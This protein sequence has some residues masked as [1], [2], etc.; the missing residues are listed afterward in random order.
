METYKVE[1]RSPLHNELINPTLK[2]KI[3]HKEITIR[4]RNNEEVE[5][6]QR[7]I[8]HST[9]NMYQQIPNMFTGR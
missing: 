1:I 2:H 7:K 3:T 8:T 6:T 4:P 9:P 5:I